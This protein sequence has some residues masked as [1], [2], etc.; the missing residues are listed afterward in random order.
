MK[1]MITSLALIFSIMLVPSLHAKG[2]IIK[3]V[4]YTADGQKHVVSKVPLKK[5]DKK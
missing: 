2:T 5:K 1:V 3:T 4:Y